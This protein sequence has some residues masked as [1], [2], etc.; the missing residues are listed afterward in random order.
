MELANINIYIQTLL[1]ENLNF[2]NEGLKNNEKLIRFAN[3]VMRDD[4]LKFI[5][6][7]QCTVD[8]KAIENPAG[9]FIGAIKNELNRRGFPKGK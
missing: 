6:D 2:T 3:D 4:F 1:I 7:V 8:E 5:I 9:Y